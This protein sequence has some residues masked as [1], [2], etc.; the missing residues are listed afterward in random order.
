MSDS[1]FLPPRSRI[2]AGFT[3]IE[4]IVVVA[5]AVILAAI[6]YPSYS[7]LVR[8]A[9][10]SEAIT[11]LGLIQQAQE[12]YRSNNSKYASSLATLPAPRPVSPTT[13]GSYYTLTISDESATGYTATA[14]AAAK[15]GQNK[16]IE[17]TSLSVTISRGTITQEPASCWKQ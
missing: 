15:R 12:R 11:A 4:L 7:D 5:V 1:K 6:A 13:P 9:R 10:R 3:L 8:T 14:T 2:S 16:D 17:C